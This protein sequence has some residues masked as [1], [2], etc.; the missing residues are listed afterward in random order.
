MEGA[1]GV[2]S[3]TPFTEGAQLWLGAACA[4]SADLHLRGYFWK[5]LSIC[6]SAWP[7]SVSLNKST[8]FQM[9]A[10]PGERGGG[11]TAPPGVSV[12]RWE[13]FRRSSAVA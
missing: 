5:K 13:H 10:V 4:D 1:P 3:G 11:G 2:W 12:T 8:P 9:A 6:W 7:R